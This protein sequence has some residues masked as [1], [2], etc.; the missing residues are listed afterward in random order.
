VTDEVAK[1][2]RIAAVTLFE[3][4]DVGVVAATGERT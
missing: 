3:R 1:V 4:Y 2:L